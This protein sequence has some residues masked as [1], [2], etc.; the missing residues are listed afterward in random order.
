MLSYFGW[1]SIGFYHLFI[2]PSMC[3][4]FFNPN[5]SLDHNVSSTF[6]FVL[7]PNIYYFLVDT[8]LVVFFWRSALHQK[9]KTKIP[10]SK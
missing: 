1:R 9:N 4:F 5:A 7:F 2:N 10:T 6:V 8:L 3:A